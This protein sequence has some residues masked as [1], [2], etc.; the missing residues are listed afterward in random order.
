L[1]CKSGFP[2]TIGTVAANYQCLYFWHLI[3]L[4]SPDDT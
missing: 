4:P 2:L 1:A 3:T